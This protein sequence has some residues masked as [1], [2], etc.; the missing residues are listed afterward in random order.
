MT[1]RAKGWLMLGPLTVFFLG[2]ALGA[3]VHERD[4]ER[5]CTNYGDA[6]GWFVS[7]TCEEMNK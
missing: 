7:I 5:N 1:N 4:M 2:Y 6:N 3:I